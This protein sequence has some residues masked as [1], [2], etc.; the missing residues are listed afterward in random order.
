[1]IW[2]ALTGANEGNSEII[3]E[4]TARTF[5]YNFIDDKI[6]G[7]PSSNTNYYITSAQSKSAPPQ[8]VPDHSYS[9]LGWY[10]SG[11]NYLVHIF[12]PWGIDPVNNT[13]ADNN[14]TI[15]KTVLAKNPNIPFLNDSN[16]GTFVLNLTDFLANFV[17]IIQV[18][19]N[20]DFKP[21]TWEIPLWNLSSSITFVFLKIVDSPYCSIYFD[22]SYRGVRNQIQPYSIQVDVNYYMEYGMY[23]T[24]ENTYYGMYLFPTYNNT[25]LVVTRFNHDVIDKIYATIYA[26]NGTLN[27][28]IQNIAPKNCEDQCNSHGTCQ[29]NQCNCTSSVIFIYKI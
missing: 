11:Y 28:A 23:N 12:N 1:M 17:S 5:R 24:E 18:Y 8:L 7:G 26:P 4:L 15:W 21:M 19:V 10:A 25:S 9:I 22:L 29:N 13:F 20:Y 14:Q 2:T 3:A 16:D 27:M 6:E